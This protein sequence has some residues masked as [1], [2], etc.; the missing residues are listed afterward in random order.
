MVVSSVGW[1]TTAETLSLRE[2]FQ[3]TTPLPPFEVGGKPWCV[4]ESPGRSE[5]MMHPRDAQRLLNEGIAG[6]EVRQVGDWPLM[7]AWQIQIVELPSD[8][9]AV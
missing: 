3:F 7:N 4:W 5:W 1:Q 9:R 2:E 8:S 6:C